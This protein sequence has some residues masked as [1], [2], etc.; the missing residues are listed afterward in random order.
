MRRAV[1]DL[2]RDPRKVIQ[3]DI[4]NG[5][6][7]DMVN[8]PLYAELL[9]LAGDG[10]AG[11]SNWRAELQNQVEAETCPEG[12]LSRTGSGLGERSAVGRSTGQ[13]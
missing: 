3:V 7:W 11:G 10:P 5:P 4:L 9:Y 8:G 12:R 6:Q 13:S 2:A 1:K